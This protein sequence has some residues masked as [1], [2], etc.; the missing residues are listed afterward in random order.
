MPV[1]TSAAALPGAGALQRVVREAARRR[2]VRVALLVGG[3]FA[4]GVL[5]GGRASA[6]ES[7]SAPSPLSSTVTGAVTE[8][9]GPAAEQVARPVVEQAMR[10]VVE[11]AVRPVGEP[12]V[13][14]V[15]RPVTEQVVRPVVEDVVRP[16]TEQVVVPVGELVESVTEGLGGVTSQLPPVSGLPSLPG[17]PELPELP[18]LPGWTTL[19]V[20]APPVEVTPLE[21]GRAAAERPG[22]TVADDDGGRDGERTSGP[23]AG[24]GYGPHAAALGAVA[25][26]APRRDTGAG[27]ASLVRVPAQQHPDGLPTGTPSRT[28]SPPSTGRR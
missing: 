15:V 24:V 25:V 8:A 10:P 9:T 11:Q 18:A 7:T 21:P 6:T 4:L 27:V 1:L 22:P 13:E 12:V 26:S 5:C 3:L 20:E 28:P 14:H 19:P 16:V 23:H 17:V 2:A